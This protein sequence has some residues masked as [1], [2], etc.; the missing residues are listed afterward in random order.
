MDIIIPQNIQTKFLQ[1]DDNSNKTDVR[2]SKTSNIGVII[3]SII[4][5]FIIFIFWQ[6]NKNKPMQQA[7]IENSNDVIQQDNSPNRTVKRQKMFPINSN[8][9]RIKEEVLKLT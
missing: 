8:I 5:L 4:V 9:L 2:L 7:V 6:Y 1:V 3:S